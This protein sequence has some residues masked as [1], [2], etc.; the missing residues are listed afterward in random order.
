[1]RLKQHDVCVAI[2]RPVMFFCL[3]R[4]LAPA[5]RMAAGRGPGFAGQQQNK[6]AGKMSWFVTGEGCDGG[7]LDF[8]ALR[9]DFRRDF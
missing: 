7:T 2:V 5:Q 1:M 6:P 8:D 4:N 9:E 3:L